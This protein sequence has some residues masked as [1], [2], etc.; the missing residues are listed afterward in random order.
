ME[1]WRRDAEPARLLAGLLRQASVQ[2]TR[3]S[4]ER[5]PAAIWHEQ[6]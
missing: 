3:V 4:V 5:L 2:L 1:H 6:G